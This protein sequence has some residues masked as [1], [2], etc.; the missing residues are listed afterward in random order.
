MESVHSKE[1]GHND[2]K[3]KGQKQKQPWSSKVLWV[4]SLRKGTEKAHLAPVL[5]FFL[6]PFFILEVSNV[7]ILEKNKQT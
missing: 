4:R 2:V 7:N 3:V 1:E 5:T 6:H